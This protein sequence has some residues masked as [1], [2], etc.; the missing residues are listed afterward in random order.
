[1]RTGRSIGK[2]VLVRGGL[3]RVARLAGDLAGYCK[4]ETATVRTAPAAV[5]EI[6]D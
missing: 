5:E 4:V 3:E 1:M 2:E 6:L